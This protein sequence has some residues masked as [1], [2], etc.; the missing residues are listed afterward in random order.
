MTT[1]N[2]LLDGA[3]FDACEDRS[4]ALDQLAR[5]R[6][7]TADEEAEYDALQARIDAH[8]AAFDETPAEALC[9]VCSGLMPRDEQDEDH[10]VL[11]GDP[12]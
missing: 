10:H 9:S 6:P 5:T 2:P 1:P 3:A 4:F 7:L 8:I 11:C 12:E